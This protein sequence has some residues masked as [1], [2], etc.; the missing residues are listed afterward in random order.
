MS[1]IKKELSSKISVCVF[2]WNIKNNS[3]DEN[4]NKFEELLD[5]SQKFHPDLILLPEM[6]SCGFCGSRLAAEAELFNERVDCCA[7]LAKKYNTWIAAGSIP[8]TSSEKSSGKVFNTLPLISA[9]GKLMYKFRKMHLFVNSTEPE[10]FLPGESIPEPFSTGSWKIGAGICF[11][12]RFPEVFRIQMLAE[13]NLFLLP[14]QFPD[15]R[16][17]HFSLLSASR[18]L[19][20]QSYMIAGNRTGEDGRLTFSGGSQVNTPEGK[21]IAIAAKTDEIINCTIDY[22]FLNDHRSKFPFRKLSD[23]ISQE[24]K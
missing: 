20:N 2:Q 1:G 21:T 11:D 19:E 24:Q 14:A 13:A 23:A 17:D 16:L 7:F 4:R 12:L 3:W 10:Y 9:E 18:A 15:P 22:D 6:W 5:K 8:E